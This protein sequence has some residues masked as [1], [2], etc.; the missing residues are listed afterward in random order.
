MGIT[1][2]IEE[3]QMETT[4]SISIRSAP[5]RPRMF[6]TT[7]QMTIPP[8]FTGTMWS[9]WDMQMETLRSIS[10]RLALAQFQTFPITW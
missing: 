7:R 3:K 1:W 8:R 2:C 4:K 5:A 10:T 6:P 9:G